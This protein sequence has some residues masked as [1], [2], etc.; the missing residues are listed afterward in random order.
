MMEVAFFV[1]LVVVVSPPMTGLVARLF[2]RPFF[3]WAFLGL[4]LPGISLFLLFW[5]SRHDVVEEPKPREEK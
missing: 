5:V 3:K 4:V 1:F 2:D